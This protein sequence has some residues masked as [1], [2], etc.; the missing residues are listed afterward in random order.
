VSRQ[1]GLAYELLQ[2]DSAEASLLDLVDHLLDKGCVLTGEIV[3]G[4]ADI[5]LIYLELSALLCP[6]DRLEGTDE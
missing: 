6:V 5:D 4:L 2:G 3:L 1:P